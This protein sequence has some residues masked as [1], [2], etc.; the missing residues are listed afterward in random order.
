MKNELLA[1]NGK[2]SNLTSEQY[3]LVRTPAFIKWFGNWENDPANAS[4]VVDDNGEPLVVYHGTR[5]NFTEFK[6]ND[7]LNGIGS[8]YG[9]YFTDNLV[10][11]K[12]YGKALSVFLNIK[13]PLLIDDYDGFDRIFDYVAKKYVEEKYKGRYDYDKLIETQNENEESEK[14]LETIYDD[15]LPPVNTDNYFKIKGNLMSKKLIEAG[16]DG[17]IL[18]G[19]RQIFSKKDKVFC[20]FRANQIKLA[21]GTNKTFDSSNDDIRFEQ[22]GETESGVPDYLRMFLGK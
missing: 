9:F 8:Y 16:H 10:Y 19:D 11:A 18:K 17:F 1:P 4:K 15:L 13:N 5:T 3:K 14:I 20:V 12:E 2:P 22:G 6:M 7:D 21:D